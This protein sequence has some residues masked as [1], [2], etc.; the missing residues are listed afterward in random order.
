MKARLGKPVAH[1]PAPPQAAAKPPMPPTVKTPG[2][3]VVN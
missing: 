1:A 2:D 3:V